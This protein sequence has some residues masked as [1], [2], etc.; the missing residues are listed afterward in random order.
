[1]N[2][3]RYNNDNGLIC[4]YCDQHEAISE[5]MPYCILCSSRSDGLISALQMINNIQKEVNR[6]AVS[7]QQRN[8]Q[9][10][11]LEFQICI[12]SLDSVKQKIEKNPLLHLDQTKRGMI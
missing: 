8:M 2:P 9:D 7:F 11:L 6:I 4:P 10:V 5:Y 1:M 12:A 3:K